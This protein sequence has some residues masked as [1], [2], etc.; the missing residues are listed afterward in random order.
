MNLLSFS[1][2]KSLI[3]ECVTVQQR[4]TEA[5]LARADTRKQEIGE[6]VGACA[7]AVSTKPGKSVYNVGRHK[8]QT[9]IFGI[10]HDS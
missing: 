3:H 9:G 1:L 5:D 7:P 8:Y 4:I 2:R 10:M 6:E